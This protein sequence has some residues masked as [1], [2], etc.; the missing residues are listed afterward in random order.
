MDELNIQSLHINYKSQKLIAF[1][2]CIGVCWTKKKS[3]VH[4]IVAL[5]SH[6]HAAIFEIHINCVGTTFIALFAF[7]VVAVQLYVPTCG[8]NDTIKD[9]DHNYFLPYSDKFIIP[10]ELSEL[11][12]SEPRIWESH[13]RL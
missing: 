11:N 4:W 8:W 12:R 2:H 9:N 3:D 10:F 6:T 1:L 7:F 5:E 13:K